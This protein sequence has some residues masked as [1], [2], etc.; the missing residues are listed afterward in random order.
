MIWETSMADIFATLKNAMMG[1]R[2]RTPA[3]DPIPVITN[4]MIARSDPRR[5]DDLAFD[6]KT[7]GSQG[8]P[9]L[10]PSVQFNDA[11]WDAFM[12]SGP[13]SQNIEDRRSE[14][15]NAETVDDFIA[16]TMEARAR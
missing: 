11:G 9:G 15:D 4:A 2:Q 12:N 14:T 13:M 3:E 1:P 5:M 8:Y 6:Q 7:M 10:P 16:R